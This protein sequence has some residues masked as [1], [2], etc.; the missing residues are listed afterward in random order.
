MNFG[1]DEAQKAFAKLAKEFLDRECGS[2]IV[3]QSEELEQGFPVELYQKLA[4]QGLLGLNIDE[5]FGGSAVGYTEIVLFC[6]QAGSHLLP[7]PYIPL[8]VATETIRRHGTIDQKK[9][10]LPL[11]AQGEAIPI[12]AWLENSNDYQFEQGNLQSKAIQKDNVYHLKGS[13]NFVPFG[14]SAT[15]LLWLAASKEE[16]RT[17]DQSTLF[18]L[19]LREK[20]IQITNFKT[21]GG[22]QI[23]DI[24]I[25]T[26]CPVNETVGAPDQG[27]SILGLGLELGRIATAAYA[28]G[29]AEKALEMGVQYAT[30]RHQFGRPIGSFQAIQHKLANCRCL[31]EQ[32]KWLTFHAAGLKD[33]DASTSG[34]A[35]MAKLAACR[36]FKETATTSSL[37]HGGYGFMQEYD[38]QLYFRRAKDLENWCGSLLIDR[39]LILKSALDQAE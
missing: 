14:S 6:Q 38:I 22:A 8:L 35:S 33:G 32:A 2:E 36:A 16:G 20:S 31:I 21:Q 26:E 37:V 27:W 13:K 24:N 11:I 7:G 28:L 39:D 25:K 29:A 19:P 18:L 23:S 34:V 4:N 3:R 15:H 30:E 12:P 10:L 5:E 17:S 1:L 9:K